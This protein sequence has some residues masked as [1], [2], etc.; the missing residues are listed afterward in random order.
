[1]EPLFFRALGGESYDV[2]GDYYLIS[3]VVEEVAPPLTKKQPVY[4]HPEKRWV[5]L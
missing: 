2:E 5:Y 3:F 1:L 4:Q